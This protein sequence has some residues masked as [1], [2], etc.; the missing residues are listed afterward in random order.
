MANSKDPLAYPLEEVLGIKRRRVEEAEKEVE[1]KKQ[2]LQ[3]QQEILAKKE[4]E[5]DKVLNHRNDKLAQLRKTMDSECYTREIEQA[6]AYLKIVKK[7]LAEEEKKVEEQKEQVNI[8]EKNLE[9]AKLELAKRRKE[10]D[11]LVEHKTEW[12][13]EARKELEIEEGRELDE[14]G[15][16]I[17][18]GR[19][20][21]ERRR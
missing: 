20:Q 10:V 6:R 8:A 16:M 9:L 21:K 12:T 18:L 3:K 2:E 1:L 15:S 13:K 11:K 19:M 7:R 17:F 4:A 14:M 5:R